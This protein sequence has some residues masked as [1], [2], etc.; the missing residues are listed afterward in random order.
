MDAIELAR[1][2]AAQRHEA[3]V[4]Q[5]K[6]PR[7][8]YEFAVSEA[9]RCDLDVERATPGATHLHGGRATFI[10]ADRLII[11]ED[12][13]SDFDRAFLVAHEIG[14]EFTG[15]QG[16]RFTPTNIDPIRPAEASPIGID[17]VVDYSQR[18][19][20]EVQMDLFAREFLLPR[21][22]LRRM[23]V[24][25][26]MTATQIAD[27]FHAPFEVVAQQLLDAVLL[28]AQELTPCDTTDRQ[29]NNEQL[30]AARHRGRAYLL[31]AG[32]GTGKTQ[33]LVLRIKGLLSEGIEPAKILLLTFSNKAAGEMSERIA[34]THAKEAA[35]MWV[36]TFHAFGLEIVRR[37]HDRLGL[38]ADPRLLDRTEALELLEHEFPRLD[39]HHYA[40]LYDPTQNITDL[41]A[42]ISRAKDEVVD[43]TRYAQLAAAMMSGTLTDEERIAAEKVAE[44]ARVYQAYEEL[45][46]QRGCVDFGDLV[47]LPA[48]LLEQDEAVRT[49][50]QS[51]YEHVLVDEYQ[52][53]NRSSVRLLKAL[54]PSG[55]NLWVVGDA[56]QSIYRF[57]GAS[58]YNLTRFGKE[59][60]P[61]GERSR[62]KVNYR[63]HAEIVDLFSAF[64]RE[65]RTGGVDSALTAHRGSSGNSPE[66][67]GAS[68]AEQQILSLEESI[69]TL[70]QQGYRYRDQAVLCAGND[71]VAKVA[72]HLERLGVPVLFLGSL[73]ERSEVKDCFALLSLFVDRRGAGLVRVA[74][75]PEFPLCLGEVGVVLAHLQHQT[76]GDALSW[77]QNPTILAGI[78]STGQESLRRL[79]TVLQGFSSSTSPWLA[80]TKILLDRTRRAARIG[81]ST[82]I[83]DR[84]RGIA[85]WQLLNFLRMQPAAQGLPVRRL[86]DRVKRLVRL[87]DDRDLR[88]LPAAAQG[89]DAVRL[90][91]IHGSKGLEFRAVHVPGMNKN[92]FPW[93]ARTSNCPPP[94]GM[95]E[96][97][98]GTGSEAAKA[99][100]ETEQECLFYVAL[101]RARDRL[102]LYYA[103]RKSNNVRWGASSFVE[104]LGAIRSHV[105]VTSAR[106]LPALSEDE[107]IAV[108]FDSRPNYKVSQ[109]ALYE[110]CPRRFF[111]TFLLETGGRRTTTAFMQMHE[112]IRTVYQA[113]VAGSMPADANELDG[114]LERAFVEQNLAG[115]GYLE[116]YRS[117]AR[118]IIRYFISTRKGHTAERPFA[119]RLQLGE[120]EII[121]QPDDILVR[122]DGV[123]LV[124]RI[125]TG[126][127][128]AEDAKDIS[129]SAL[130]LAARREYPGAVVE[131]VYLSERTLNQA[132][133]TER[134]LAN[135]SE[136]LQDALRD[137]RA[138]KFPADPESRKC[139]TC[140]AFF[141]CGP[142][143]SGTLRKNL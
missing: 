11:H 89:L 143:P 57:R 88:Q 61:G 83:E 40:D 4:A 109:I 130:L 94:P 84:A 42:A 133:P 134:I 129:S 31:E 3:A 99:E 92:S 122:A 119:L 81:Q 131:L 95:I 82:L 132:Q 6:D 93:T 14:H 44:V 60:F 113:V 19:R 12:C 59:D 63:S 100:H 107:P 55:D 43:A 136:A 121:V 118:N 26:G 103:E 101:S 125:N 126:Y 10:A 124:R 72:A 111:Y 53:V 102:R 30:N 48:L 5:G 50:V 69:Q 45:K 56:R 80:M 2:V 140:P 25:Q 68:N 15:D 75:G 8:P 112:A 139:P 54:R 73:F 64:A 49:L 38:P 47:L 29:P 135:Q 39:L 23:H 37:F 98:V 117:F 116:Q 120:E 141:I 34:R 21:E 28:P 114:H 77:L 96:G 138:G 33:T 70:V 16:D 142:V 27:H 46:R 22:V 35:A 24:D 97:A 128:R 20:R 32:P 7:R 1:R 106:T 67:C 36:G 41:L 127:A 9:H 17:R 90:M 66:I 123:R 18:Q 85:L 87:G 86:L 51:R 71:S 137:I 91:T 108:T 110:R 65:M 62:L 105:N 78:S 79:S 115:H 13:G 74:T 76:E 104:R 52:D 58:S